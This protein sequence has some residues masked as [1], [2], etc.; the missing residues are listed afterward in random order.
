MST[1]AKA[2]GSSG[3]TLTE[4]M[5]VVVVVGLL[6]S[7]AVPNLGGA[8]DSARLNMIYSNLRVLEQAK[9]Q[10]AMENNKPPGATVDNLAVLNG[11]FRNGAIRDVVRE[12]YVANPVGT[13]AAANLPGDTGLGP[14]SPGS[15]IPA[16]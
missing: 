13:P 15:S 1:N 3:F 7:L 14:F 10:W 2:K 12:T 11:Y 8:R 16:Q 4:V 6:A 5:I 9:E